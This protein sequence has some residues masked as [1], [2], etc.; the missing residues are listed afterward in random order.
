MSTTQRPV[1]FGYPLAASDVGFID[2]DTSLTA[3][4][5]SL[6]PSQHAVRTFVN[7]LLTGVWKLKGTLNCSSNPNYPSATQSDAYVASA[8]GKVGGASGTTVE[9]GDFI[10]ALATNAGGTQASVGTSWTVIQA[11]LV[12]ALTTATVWSGDLGGTGA[13]PTVLALEESGGQRLALGAIADG[14][15]LQRVGTSLVG[16]AML[17]A[18]FGDGSDGAVTFDGSAT[19]LGLVP[20]GGVYTLTSD[21]F[22]A[23]GSSITNAATIKGGGFVIY[24]NGLLTHDGVAH[25]DGNAASGAT[26]GAGLGGASTGTLWNNGSGAGA[27]GRSTTGSGS[28]AGGVTNCPLGAGGN[29]GG[30]GTHSGGN[31]ATATAPSATLGSHKS[32]MWSLLNCRYITA[33]ASA[34]LQAPGLGPGGGSG[35][36]DI[37]GGGT[38]TS[39]GGGGGAAILAIRAR[40]LAGSGTIRANGGRGGD[41]VQSGAGKAGGGGGGSGGFVDI[42][43][44]STSV[45][46][47]TQANGGSGG[48]GAGTGGAS[49]T[50]G[51]AGIIMVRT[52]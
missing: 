48:S 6:V 14:Q 40:R 30:D 42:I 25:A 16:V 45:S 50:S 39:G 9:V 17:S 41:A 34:S 23:D 37:S 4:S 36:C 46:V 5:D 33:A 24:C 8:A 29:G 15:R 52:V 2:T 31:G 44:T 18:L 21:I 27:A 1:R 10:F 11:N 35:A 12:S 13:S 28:N 43:T 26:A 3:D 19:V 32:L 38:A 7:A 22:L 47:T 49:G 20:S 51:S